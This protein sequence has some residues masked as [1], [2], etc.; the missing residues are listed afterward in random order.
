[1]YST[2]A[3]YEI[4]THLTREERRNDLSREVRIIFAFAS[5]DPNRSFNFR[6]HSVIV[7]FIL[8][9]WIRNLQKQQLLT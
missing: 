1:M 5:L 2:K 8:S 4:I 3:G 9:I 6:E 7:S